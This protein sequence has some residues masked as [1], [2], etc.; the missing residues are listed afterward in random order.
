MSNS[1]FPSTAPRRRIWPLLLIFGLLV[2]LAVAWTG[3]WFH[4]AAQA[5]TAIAAWFDHERQAGRQQDCASLS[6]GGYPFRIE[7]RCAGAGFELAEAPGYRLNLPSVLAMVQI[8]DPKLMISE[9]TGPLNVS[10]RRGEID[11]VVNWH[12]GRASMRGLPPEAERGSLA[13]DNLSVRDGAATGSDPVFGAEHFELHGRR[14]PGSRSDEPAIETILKLKDAIAGKIHL[15]LARPIDADVTSVVHGLDGFSRKPLP[16]QLKQWQAHNGEVEITEA[17][18]R[19]DDVIAV[20]TGTLRLTARGGL[21]GNLR[22]TIVG[23]EKLLRM[24]D[25]E[26]LMSEG[27]MGATLNALDQL[28]PGLGGIARRSAAP[29]LVAVLGQRGEFDG[30]PATTLPV[31]FVDGTVFLGPFPVGVVPPLF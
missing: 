19:Q 11:Y 9:M 26:R 3:L 17:R 6:I 8:Y 23:I 5:R 15:A 7:V 31:R 2:A 16:D 10:E 22:V 21:D 1:A 29:G 25:L 12:T 24:F 4:V 20:G 14:A 28:M 30:K 27:Q 13:F 18:I